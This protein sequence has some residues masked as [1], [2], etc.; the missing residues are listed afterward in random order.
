MTTARNPSVCLGIFSADDFAFSWLQVYQH[1][2]VFMRSCAHAPLYTTAC[3]A[4][5]CMCCLVASGLKTSWW[6]LLSSSL[7]R[8]TTTDSVAVSL[9]DQTY[10]GAVGIDTSSGNL[11]HKSPAGRKNVFLSDLSTTG[12]RGCEYVAKSIPARDL[13]IGVSLGRI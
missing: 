11:P 10:P 4:H 12:Q 6:R 1:T 13:S 5:Q 9:I 7:L 2:R 8:S 3:I